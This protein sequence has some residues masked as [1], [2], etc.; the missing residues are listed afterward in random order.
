[1]DLKRK[2][3]AGG[4]G[5]AMLAG[6]GGVYAATNGDGDKERE[7]FADNVAKRL[8]VTPE[9]LDEAVQGAFKD[10][11]DA[12]VKAGKLT[13]KQ[14]DEIEKRVKE[15]GGVPFG[16]P[17][18]GGPGFG[19]PGFGKGG[20]GGPGG[21]HFRD[22]PGPGGPIGAGFDAAAKYLGISD[23]ELKK[24]LGE[25]KSLA[26][27][28]KAENKSTDGLKKAL[29]EAVAAKLDKAVK[30]ED[31]TDKQ[32]DGI[33]ERFDEHA[34]DIIAG[35][36]PEKPEFGKRFHHDGDGPG[37]GMHFGGPPP[38]DAVPAP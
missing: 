29:R 16:G 38:P 10:R 30:D 12:A 18:F 20:P 3:V 14:A 28:A 11:L 2:I 24:Q 32:R 33:L 15:H 5:L 22:G 27:I 4:A 17:G 25:G 35:K 7:A 37:P 6:A 9:K 8:N 13:Q 34:D 23:A 21:F 1:M 31:L 19:G 36:R 26:E